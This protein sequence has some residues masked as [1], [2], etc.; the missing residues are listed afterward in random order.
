MAAQIARFTAS[1]A[2]F[3]AAARPK[4]RRAV[5]PD[6]TGPECGKRSADADGVISAKS[7]ALTAI[8]TT[9]GQTNSS[10]AV[11]YERKAA[12]ERKIS[13]IFEEEF[14]DKL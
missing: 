5:L 7:A 11:L 6:T 2:F 1:G 13:K 8:L 10:G 3:G 12:D 9:A 4:R 14:C